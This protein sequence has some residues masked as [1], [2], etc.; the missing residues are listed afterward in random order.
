M[1]NTVLERIKSPVVLTAVL[2]QVI[3]IIGL[4]RPDI[5][6]NIKIAGTAVIEVLT[7]IGI[8]NNP[9]EKKKF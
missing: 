5:T 2:A 1:R 6:E 3:L 7:L 4:I 9:S 8:L